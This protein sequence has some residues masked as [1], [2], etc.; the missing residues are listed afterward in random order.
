MRYMITFWLDSIMHETITEKKTTLSCYWKVS[1]TTIHHRRPQRVLN[2]LLRTRLAEPLPPS[3]FSNVYLFLCLP[4]CRRW[5]LLKGD[6]NH[7]TRRKLGP[8]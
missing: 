1:S 5:S 8:L 7:N 2:D 4:M 6:P 3:P